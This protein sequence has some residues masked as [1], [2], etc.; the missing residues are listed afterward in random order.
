LLPSIGKQIWPKNLSRIITEA[1]GIIVPL[2]PWSM[3]GVYITGTIG[4]PTLA[5]LP[6]ALMN[7]LSVL[8]LL[9]YG[10]T[11]SDGASVR[12]DPDRQLIAHRPR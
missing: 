1:G 10:F 8:L 2:V 12:T 9:L 11:D 6:W 7:Y 5:Y 4:V 3:A